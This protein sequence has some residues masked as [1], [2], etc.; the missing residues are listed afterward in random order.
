[1]L[2]IAGVDQDQDQDQDRATIRSPGFQKTLDK[3]YG[4]ALAPDLADMLQLQPLPGRRP[5]ELSGGQ[6]RRVAIPAEAMPRPSRRRR[7]RTEA[8]ADCRVDG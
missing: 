8:T 3:D 6:R 4:C 2:K 1:M 7:S 5:S